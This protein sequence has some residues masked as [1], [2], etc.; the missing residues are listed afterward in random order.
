M[1]W[2]LRGTAP[3][4]DKLVPK[5]IRRCDKMNYAAIVI[6]PI[7]KVITG[8]ENSASDM[9]QFVNQF[10]KIANALGSSIIYAHHHS[11]GAQGSK[12]SMD[13]ASGSGVF[14]RDP[15]ALLD[16]IELP[17]PGETMKRFVS[18]ARAAAIREKL[19]TM[20]PNWRTY[21]IERMECDENDA[22]ALMNYASEMLEPSQIDEVYS[23]S[24][25]AEV[26][27]RRMTALRIS[28]T[29]REFPSFE[30][31]DVFF[32]YPV[33]VLDT[34][35]IMAN[36][37]PEGN[38]QK[39]GIDVMRDAKKKENDQNIEMFLNAFDEL[40]H[41]GCVTVKELAESGLIPGKSESAI[42]AMLNR[43]TK[44]GK[45]D[46]FKYAKGTVTKVE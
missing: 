1:I 4:L 17:I 42:R 46:G 41:D 38:I 15:D 20:V 21:L 28:G 12:K 27:A 36:V 9:A 7:Y 37:R 34:S 14:A 29:L 26:M 2:N 24:Y 16:I 43:W 3:T 39:R 13:R 5:L 8:D 33:H 44:A 10:D 22:D 31:I 45:I 32:R 40:E 19:D 35:G 23:S 18:D 25:E 30:P 6:D 11:K